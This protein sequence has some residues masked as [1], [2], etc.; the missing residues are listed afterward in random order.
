MSACV[1]TCTC[2]CADFGEKKRKHRSQGKRRACLPGA[3]TWG[4]GQ[5]CLPSSHRKGSGGF[6]RQ[7]L[8]CFVLHTATGQRGGL[9]HTRPGSGLR[10]PPETQPD[11]G[12]TPQLF[13]HSST[14]YSSWRKTWRDQQ[15]RHSEQSQNR[16]ASRMKAV[17]WEALSQ[18]PHSGQ[19]SWLSES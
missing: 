8:D 11:L 13:P 14:R 3:A 5:G 19:S 2:E 6:G 12:P 16:R 10:T 18:P 7:D 4:R 15:H 17:E 9:F 1:Y